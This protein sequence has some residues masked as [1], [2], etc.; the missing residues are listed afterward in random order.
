[1]VP[2]TSCGLFALC[3]LYP[4]CRVGLPWLIREIGDNPLGDF[5]PKTAEPPP[6]CKAIGARG[7]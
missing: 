6:P 3:R 4:V 7:F 5:G 2:S 1:L